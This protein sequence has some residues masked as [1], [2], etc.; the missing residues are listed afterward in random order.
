MVCLFWSTLPQQAR[1]F[2]LMTCRLNCMQHSFTRCS[3]RSCSSCLRRGLQQQTSL[4]IQPHTD[5]QLTHWPC[6]LLLLLPDPE[7]TTRR[8]APRLSC[9]LALATTTPV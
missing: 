3:L 1:A 2:W 6:L 4:H 9:R 7:R 5:K 8:P